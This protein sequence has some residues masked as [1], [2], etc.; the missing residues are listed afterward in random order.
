MENPANPQSDPHPLEGVTV[1]DL[2][3]ALAGPFA[4]LLLAGLGA[5]VIK[6][7]NPAGGDICRANSPYLGVHGATL[8]R[9]HEDDVSISALNRLRNKLSV[10]LN[11]KNQE[12][13]DVFADLLRHAD[14]VVDNFSRGTLD[15]L[16]I[17]YAYGR[18]V[19]PRIIFHFRFW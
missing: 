17:G 6:I 15:R 8:T 19:D 5:R 9:E 10:T 2:T 11:L 18:E 14:L 3:I 12:A 7:E 13:R 1:V 4:T 16:G